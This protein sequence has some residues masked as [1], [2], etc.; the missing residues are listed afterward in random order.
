MKNEAVLPNAA[1]RRSAYYD[2]YKG[3]MIILVVFA[4]MLYDLQSSELINYITDTIY[5]FHMPAFVF[6]TGFLSKSENSRS[7][8]SLLRLFSLY[9]VFNFIMETY[10]SL[11]TSKSLQLRCF[12]SS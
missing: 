4:H 1:S 9:L 3:I 12:Q 7:G 10:H 11:I 8:K 6:S 5:V 2:N